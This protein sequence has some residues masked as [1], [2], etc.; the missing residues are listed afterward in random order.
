MNG[1]S[2]ICFGSPLAVP[3]SSSAKPTSSSARGRA[4]AIRRDVR[5]CFERSENA[6][7]RPS[8]SRTRAARPKMDVPGGAH[9][10]IAHRSRA[11]LSR[12]V[13]P[14]KEEKVIAQARNQV[15]QVLRQIDRMTEEQRCELLEAML[16]KQRRSDLG[17]AVIKRTR[18]KLPRRSEQQVKRDVDVA[19]Q[20]VR[21]EQS[22]TAPA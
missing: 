10:A 19:I 2:L 17:W 5:S 3:P 13:L 9:P 15:E 11:P 22:R 20:Q 12:S 7:R 14:L 21:R 4:G 18:S 1:K 8:P 6:K 16:L